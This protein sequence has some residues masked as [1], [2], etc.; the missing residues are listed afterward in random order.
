MTA[1][2]NQEKALNDSFRN[3]AKDARAGGWADGIAEGMEK[4]PGIN[5]QENR[6]GT[7]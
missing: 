2:F 7:R 6:S 4:G 3:E 5:A 1:L